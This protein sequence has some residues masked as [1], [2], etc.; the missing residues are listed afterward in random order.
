LVGGEIAGCNK[1][2]V[3]SIQVT[4]KAPV[5][6]VSALV[7]VEITGCSKRFVASVLITDKGPVPCVGAFVPG[8][9]SPLCGCVC[10]W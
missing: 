7:V 5:P 8:K 1:R 2:F 4:D 9:I 3:A 10:A 6:C